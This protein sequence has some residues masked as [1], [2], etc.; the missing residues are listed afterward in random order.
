MYAKNHT[1]TF[2]LPKTCCVLAGNQEKLTPA[3]ETVVEAFFVRLKEKT[4]S[5]FR[6]SQ[7]L[8]MGVASGTN[9]V[10]TLPCSII[11]N[12]STTSW[13]ITLKL[14]EFNHKNIL[15]SYSI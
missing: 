8:V 13:T 14:H 3:R 4:S 9:M 10:F 15:D 11:L 6:V 5:I 7:V 2:L 12:G 1:N